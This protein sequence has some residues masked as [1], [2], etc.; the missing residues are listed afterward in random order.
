M[1][2]LLAY[3]ILTLGAIVHIAAA[4]K[5]EVPS[6]GVWPLATHIPYS[7]LG[8]T[9]VGYAICASYAWKNPYSLVAVVVGAVMLWLEMYLKSTSGQSSVGASMA[10]GVLPLI[11]FWIAAIGSAIGIA[12][13]LWHRALLKAPNDHSR[14]A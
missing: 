5:L 12:L 1:T 14:S 11:Q 10:S 13:S 4:L 2:K 3:T 7:W 8:L 6:V 9:L